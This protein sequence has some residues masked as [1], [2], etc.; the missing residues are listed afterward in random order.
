[1][2]QKI[3]LIVAFVLMGFNSYAQREVKLYQGIPPGNLQDTDK[4][5]YVKTERGRLDSVT[6]PSITVFLP[7]KLDSAR[8][9]VI[10][11]PGGGYR[12]LSIYDAGYELARELNKV[13][14]V[15]IVLKYRTQIEGYYQDFSKVPFMDFDRAIEIIKDSAQKWSIDIKKMGVFGFSAGGHLAAFKTVNNTH[16]TPAFSVLVYPVI[17]FM[18]ELTSARTVTR[19]VLIGNNPSEEQKKYFSAELKV[20][21]GINPCLLIHAQDDGGVVV[22]NSL[23]F[24]SALT[25]AK[26]KAQMLLYQEGGHG[27]ALH[28]K[29]QNDRWLPMALSWLR[30][31]KFLINN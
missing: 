21:P 4:E 1:M 26:V 9:S 30:F 12:Y 23:A 15:A 18:D 6:I 25:K 22:Q 29:K 27:F 2:I 20:H 13:G 8:T 5:V 19:K 28:N 31:N 7:E 11:C 3:F 16:F 24:Y 14:I 10:I 17:S